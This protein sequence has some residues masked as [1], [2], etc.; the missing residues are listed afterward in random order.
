MT[1][2]LQSERIM[3]W[4][5]KGIRTG[6]AHRLPVVLFAILTLGVYVFIEIAEEMAEGEIRRIDEM[7][8][9]SLRVAGDPTTP[10]GPPWF[11]ETAVEITAIGGYPLIILTLAAVAGF[12]IVT[13]RYGAAAYAVLAVGSGALLTQTLKQYYGRPRP[14][15]VDHLDTV[16]TLSFPSGH[17]L[18]TTV[19]YL[20]I[21]SLV[22]GFLDDR[23]ARIYVLSVAVFVAF[24][25]GFSRVYVGVHWPSDVAAGWALGAAWASLSWLILHFLHLRSRGRIKQESAP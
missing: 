14:D 1:R 22:I 21:A 4:L 8:F 5:A 3:G 13:R 17:A 16:H 11:Q 20:T 10:L 2:Y 18:V 12:F 15:L 24:I 6:N 19:A 23:R 9:L 7:L 25:V